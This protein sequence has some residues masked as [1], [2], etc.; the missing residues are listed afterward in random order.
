MATLGLG[1]IGALIIV[2]LIVFSCALWSRAPIPSSKERESEQ[3]HLIGNEDD[4]D[5]DDIP[6]LAATSP[7]GIGHHN[8]LELQE[9]SIQPQL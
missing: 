6:Q 4:D 9:V 7:E 8:E 5:D 1:L 2:M 3:K